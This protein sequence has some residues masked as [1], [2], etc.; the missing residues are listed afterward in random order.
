MSDRHLA[1]AIQID[2][3][4]CLYEEAR[5]AG[6]SILAAEA[7][8]DTHVEERCQARLR[9]RPD[10]PETHHKGEDQF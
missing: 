8:A 5:D 7:Y 6:A 4:M 9:E 10:V 2:S 3:W 1:D